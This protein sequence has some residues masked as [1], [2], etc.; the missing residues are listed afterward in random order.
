MHGGFPTCLWE[1]RPDPPELDEKRLCQSLRGSISARGGFLQF[2]VQGF[3]E[4]EE[5]V[6]K[7]NSSIA[8][9]R[10][11]EKKLLPEPEQEI[12]Q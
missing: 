8:A 6:A 2:R 9:K 5:F 7:Q 3:L 11:I 12:V 4:A 1:K 10:C